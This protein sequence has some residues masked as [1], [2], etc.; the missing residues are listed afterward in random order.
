MPTE[1]LFYHLM[2]K[3]LE[4]ALP[5]LLQKCLDRDWRV[6]VQT[7]S[8]E[9]CSALDAHLWTFADDSFLPHG[10]KADGY[11]EQ[12]PIYLTAGQDNPNAAQVRFLVDRADPPALDVYQRAIFMFDGRD[13]EAVGEARLR[14]KE[15]K[16]DGFDLAYWQQTE[17]GGWEKKA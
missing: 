8:E 5:Q 1:V 15:V 10:T 4:A 12:Q 13:E 11:S 9:R 2:H 6:I 7:G 14:W 3:P 17:A 16:A